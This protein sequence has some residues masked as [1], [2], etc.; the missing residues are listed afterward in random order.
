MNIIDRAEWGARAPKRVDR[1]SPSARRLFVVHYSGGPADQSV[2]AIQDWCMDDRGF[3]DV[4]YNWL[5]RGTTGQIYEGRGWD[6]IGSH[7]KGHNTEGIGVCVISP[8]PISDAA[9]DS[10]RALYATAVRRAGHSLAIKGHRELDKTT[11]PGSMIFAWIR[12][13]GIHQHPGTARTLAVSTPWMHGSDVAQ[14]QAKVGAKPDG[15]YGPDT[16]K[17]VKAWQKDHG[18]KADGIVG[19]LTRDKMGL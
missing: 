17:R 1:V 8:G 14:V 9:K 5:V 16:E 11:C 18:L 6:V 3:N 19:P 12:A 7:T 2:R 10:V 4:D 13:G 15:V